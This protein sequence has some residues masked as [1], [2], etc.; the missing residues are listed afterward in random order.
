MFP[1]YTFILTGS[2]ISIKIMLSTGSLYNKLTK[3]A[4]IKAS[5]KY[6]INLQL[7]EYLHLQSKCSVQTAYYARIKL[8]HH[9]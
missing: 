4:I 8:I 2:P 7:L 1:S 5:L 3:K 9:G 6:M